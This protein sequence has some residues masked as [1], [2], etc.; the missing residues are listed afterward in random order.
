MDL[1]HVVPATRIRWTLVLCAAAVGA[2]A[3]SA[4]AVA[5]AQ[6][7]QALP[8]EV[9]TP[10]DF[11]PGGAGG[12][13]GT[14]GDPPP[15]A[16][17]SFTLLPDYVTSVKNQSICGSC[18]AFA[19]YGAMESTILMQGGTAQDFSEN[20]LKNYHGFNWLPCEGGNHYMHQA[21][22]S[23]LDGPVAEAD[24]PYHAYD[25]RP[26]PGGPRQAFLRR[27]ITYS[28]QETIKNAV[29]TV[30]ALYTTMY[31]SS[32]YYDGGNDTYYYDGTSAIN[33][34]VGIVGWDDAKVVTGAPNAGAWLIKNSWGSSFGDN[35]YFWIS[36]DDARAC[37]FGASFVADDADTAVRAYHYDR[38]GYITSANTPY[39]Y[40]RFTAAD[41][42]WLTA[43][44]IYAMQDG[45]QYT[46]SVYDT[47]D[48]DDAPTGLLGSITG[49]LAEGFHVLDL[50]SDI[51]LTTGDDFVVVLSME[52]GG[53]YPLAIDK[54]LAG[55]NS[56]STASLG[57]SFYSFDGLS[58]FDVVAEPGFETANFCIK[59]YAVPEP[60]TMAFLGLGA[61]GLVL[62]RR[63]RRRA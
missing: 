34:A 54:A 48:G 19:S 16:P 42:E 46:V 59:A 6:E 55:Y 39:G 32:S 31:Y 38:F 29:M 23:R 58:W 61:A 3:S 44:G 62:V 9:T 40:N 60:A 24:D 30:G 27:S 10:L 20:H 11:T 8:V 35:G 57:E 45:T 50:D 14:A 7:L 47:V 33:H 2:L 4:L 56:A 13:G 1:L 43:V 41:N 15:A 53:D 26:S 17:S 18:W 51:L 36:Y 52:N 63:R 12:S 22:L 37:S 5:P 49:T 28:T 21:Y 25:D